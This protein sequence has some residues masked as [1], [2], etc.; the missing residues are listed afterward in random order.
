MGNWGSNHMGS[1]WGW[2]MGFGGLSMILLWV[3]IIVAVV[4]LG[5]WLFGRSSS[6]DLPR[7]K[8]ALD[9]L[10]ERYARGEIGKEEFD[11]KK[12]ELE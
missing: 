9:I 2:G 6:L 4:A 10:K 12:R 8:G 3:I 5:K 11:E 1:G 7:Q